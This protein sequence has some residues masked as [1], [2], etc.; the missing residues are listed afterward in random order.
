MAIIRAKDVSKMSLK[1]KSEKLLDLKMELAKANVTA[2]KTNSK[3]KEI[4]RGI[5]RILTSMKLEKINNPARKTEEL[6]KTK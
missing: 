3:T 5:S 4:K 6:K 2:H 1:E